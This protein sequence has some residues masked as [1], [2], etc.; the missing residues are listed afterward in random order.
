MM[1]LGLGRFGVSF[2]E[3]E[4]LSI[5]S[6]PMPWVPRLVACTFEI[7][8]QLADPQRLICLDHSERNQK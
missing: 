3:P 7:L 8:T 4:R 5:V 6:L 1:T 2:P